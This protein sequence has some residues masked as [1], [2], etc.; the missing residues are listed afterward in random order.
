MIKIDSLYNT[1]NYG[2]V[3]IIKKSERTDYYV[4]QFQQTGTIKEFR[5]YQ[6]KNGCIRDPYAKKVCGVACVGNV[7]T[8]GKYKTLYNV[9]HDMIYRCYS[10]KNKRHKAY[11]NVTVAEPW[12]IFENFY[13][14]A[15]NIEGFDL[16][17]IKNGELVLAKDIKQRNKT[18]KV[19]S[20]Q[21][22]LWVEKKENNSI[23]DGQQ[24][25]FVAISPNGTLYCDY[26]ISRF[27]R[28]HG[29]ERKHISANLHNRIHSTQGW[30]FSYDKIV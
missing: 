11:Q 12:L 4:V 1:N 9:W 18:N 23:Q 30:Q 13:K 17:R 24:R 20:T 14:D 15:P 21:T 19:Y 2:P 26:N 5:S 7:K 25:S 8:K 10:E 3:R 29:L 27:A 16:E 28:E 22:C 6:I